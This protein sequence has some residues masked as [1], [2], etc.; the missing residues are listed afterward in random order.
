MEASVELQIIVD[1]YIQE[2]KGGRKEGTKENW[3]L[4]TAAFPVY[5]V[6]PFLKHQQDHKLFKL[7]EIV[8][9]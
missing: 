5:K 8:I 2:R 3:T 1:L 9:N 6:L 7:E 4:N